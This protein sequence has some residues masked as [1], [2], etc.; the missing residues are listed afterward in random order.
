MRVVIAL[1]A[2]WITWADVNVTARYVRVRKSFASPDALSFGELAVF[3]PGATNLALGN[4]AN[5]SS[6][7]CSTMPNSCEVP[8]TQVASAGV[9]GDPSL[10]ECAA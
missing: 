7:H 8:H 3:G 4:V 2:I 1:A 5:Q 6:T 10:C 9:D